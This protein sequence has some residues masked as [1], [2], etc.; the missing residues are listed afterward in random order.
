MRKQLRL[1]RLNSVVELVDVGLHHR[2]DWL[3]C[4]DRL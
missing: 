3:G 1:G 4:P 2:G